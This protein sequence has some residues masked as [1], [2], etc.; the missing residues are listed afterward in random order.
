MNFIQPSRLKPGD[1]VAIISPSAGL[2]HIYPWVYEQGLKRIEEVL[3]LT[4]VEFPTARQSPEYLSK[5]VK[6]LVAMTRLEFFP[7]L[8]R[9][10]LQQT[11]KYLWAT[12]T[13]PTCIFTSGI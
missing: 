5:H 2:P 7:I 9:L 13:A 11:L 12:A 3:Q 1:K 6:A 10:Y 8:I 4:P